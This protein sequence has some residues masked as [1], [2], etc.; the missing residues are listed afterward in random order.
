M[1][2]MPKLRHVSILGLFA[3]GLGAHAGTLVLDVN[4]QGKNLF[5]QT[6]F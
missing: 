4:Y 6:P 5:V 2:A 1:I 3:I